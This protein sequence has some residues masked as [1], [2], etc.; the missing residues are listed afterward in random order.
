MNLAGIIISIILACLVCVGISFFIVKVIK[1]KYASNC[2]KTI[3]I[4]IETI[5][6]ITLVMS[7]SVSLKQ[8]YNEDIKKA[9]YYGVSIKTTVYFDNENNIGVMK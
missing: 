2:C 1:D 6:F 9:Y 7:L 4:L 3:L 5:L 8:S